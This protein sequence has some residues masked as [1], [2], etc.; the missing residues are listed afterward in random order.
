MSWWEAGVDAIPGVGTV[1]RTGRAIAAHATGD[2]DEAS[3]QWTEAGMNA[4]GDALGLVTGGAGKVA[5]TA[6]KVGAKTVVK[7]AAKQ[8]LKQAVKVGGRAAMKAARKQLT[9]S[10]MKA[11]A[12]QYFKKKIKKEVKRAIKEKMEEYYEAAVD[13]IDEHRDELISILADA[14]GTSQYELESLD[15]QEL[16]NLAYAAANYN[17]DY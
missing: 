4:A 14:I 13:Y 7:T 15:E 2:H 8:G 3:R 5:T 11:Y 16:L 10:A 12:K 6:A 17:D 1:Y 9:T